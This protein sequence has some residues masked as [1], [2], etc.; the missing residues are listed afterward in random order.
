MKAGYWS[1]NKYYRL[2]VKDFVE[3]FCG[4]EPLKQL[5]GVR[6]KSKESSLHNLVI[7]NR[8]RVSE[9][10]SRKRQNF[11]IRQAEGIIIV[12]NMKLLKRYRK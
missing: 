7:L 4:W 6:W 12:R 9:V 1:Y 2:S 10:L 3:D 11:E 8:R 5:V